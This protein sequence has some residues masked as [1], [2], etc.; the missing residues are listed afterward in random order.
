MRI[1]V[2]NR[3]E[4]ARR[5]IRT[6]HRLGHETVAVFADPDQNAPYVGEAT[7]AVRIGP[8]SLAESYLSIDQLVGAASRT[9]A[10]AVHPGYGFLAEN[11]NF[12]R[13][14][15]SAGA[16][17]IG[18]N[19]NVI[20]LMGSKIEARRIAMQAGVPVIPGWS[21]SQDPT[22]LSLAAAQIGWPVLIKASAGGGGKGIRIAR[23]VTEFP[24]ALE[25][26]ST[27]AQRAFGDGSVIVE[28][29]IQRPRHIEVQVVG[30]RHG[31][32]AEL[33]TR[34]CSVQRR[35][36]KL[37]E[38]APAPNLDQKTRRGLRESAMNL[39]RKVGYDSAGTVEF[40]VDD[41]TGDHF[42]LE[43]NTRLQVEHT[44]TEMVTGLDLVELMIRVAAGEN[45]PL[46]SGQMS[47]TGHAF[48]ARIMAED[49]GNGFAP[50]IGTVHHLAV[51]ANARWDSAIEQGS[52]ISPF[53]DSL[54]AKLVVAGRD[55]DDALGNLRVALDNLI[56]GGVITT[57]G[58]HR[59]LVDQQPIVDGR[60]TTRFLDETE[61]P[62]PPQ[63]AVAAAAAA[64][65]GDQEGNNPTSPWTALPEFSVTP[66]Q[67]SRDLALR[68]VDG[69]IHEI[70]LE[71]ELGAR[72]PAIVDSVRRRVS[73]NVNGHT[74]SFDVPTRSERWAPSITDRKSTDDAIVAPFPALVD[75]VLVNAGEVVEG[76]QVLVV[77]EAMKM[78]HSLRSTGAAT[79]DEVRVAPGDQVASHDVLVTFAK[80][81]TEPAAT[82]ESATDESANYE[83]VTE[84][85]N[86]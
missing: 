39:A 69:E 71:G 40:I 80:P 86:E 6:A 19:P 9:D 13:T 78:L 21:E 29:Y 10:N 51:P 76:D 24:A 49:A 35:Y 41:E 62:P 37:L 74:H 43:M 52:E 68:S 25:E 16:T 72:Y 17:W 23:D 65:A 81:A 5:I 26:A 79:V 67:M 59:W 53:Y 38:E 27:E 15:V 50:Q 84:Q 58:F 48:E 33:G 75:Q 8:A 20:E 12:A 11:A 2:A 31:A 82:D 3:G 55:R 7:M 56:V 22:A 66:H 60:V 57:A 46:T 77:I 44:V 63:P 18:P 34:E 28:R 36:Q 4:I 32:I 14:V 47:I 85:V 64:W 1:L 70:V 42:F 73:V 45:L 54:I 30:D 83:S 61:I